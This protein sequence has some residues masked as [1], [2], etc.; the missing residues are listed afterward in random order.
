[1]SIS[2]REVSVAGYERV[3]ALEAAVC[4]L[5]GYLVVHSTTLGPALGGT[6]LWRYPSDEAMLADGLALGRAMTL[7]A[8]LAELAAGGGKIVLQDSVALEREAALRALGQ[9]LESLGGLIYT[10][11]DVGFTARDLEIVRQETRFISCGTVP[12]VGSLDY[13]TAFGVWQG[14]CA[15][16]EAAF[17]TPEAGGRSVA[18]QGLGSVGWELA[19]LLHQHGA[20]LLVADLD[21]NKVARAREEFGATVVPPEEI[22]ESAADVFAPCAL[23]GVLTV[24]NAGAVKARV[25]AGSANNPLADIDAAWELHRR[26][27][28]CLPDFLINAGALIMGANYYLGGR[29]DSAAQ[30]EAIFARAQRIL[31]QARAQQRPPQ[32]IAEELALARLEQAGREV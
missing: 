4:G 6:R 22:V 24:E 14:M 19:R 17:G 30:V 15:G 13:W 2:A 32:L 12:G 3:L 27:I 9:F 31:A 29:T 21:A 1:M 20:R 23:G 25:I 8:A 10:G 5:G 11:P 28:V 16:L 18:V 7:K 26:G